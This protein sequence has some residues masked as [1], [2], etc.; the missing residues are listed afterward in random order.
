[1]AKSADGKDLTR[2]HKAYQS[3]IAAVSAIEARLLWAGLNV[4]DIDGS[5]P[6]WLA[7]TSAVV[8]RQ[9]EV[10]QDAAAIY[11]GSYSAAETGR[12]ADAV[13]VAPIVATPAVLYFAGP[14]RIKTL[15]KGGM[16]P[17][18]AHAKSLTK[19]AGA[20]HRQTLM[21]GRL[22]VAKSTAQDRRAIG[23]RRVTDGNPCAF[24]AM[25]ASRGAVYRDNISAA[26][27]DY[28]FEC[29]CTPEAEYS[30]WVPTEQEEVYLDSYQRALGDL[31]REGRPHTAK[32]I[33][34]A[35]RRVDGYR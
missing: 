32:N 9:V 4:D 12:A 6:A 23:W 28:H 34:A 2:A 7:A 1:M 3:S 10:S 26:G 20:A 16:D 21:A 13:R 25:L 24:C 15:I 22:T 35:M 8:N 31:S 27:F 11:F 33:L 30:T 18:E 5:T 29:N 17:V 14:V 19:L